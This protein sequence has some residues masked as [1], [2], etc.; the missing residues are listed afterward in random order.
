LAF[1]GNNGWPSWPWGLTMTTHAPVGRSGKRKRDCGTL[2]VKEINIFSRGATRLVSPA[3]SDSSAIFVS[4]SSLV[5]PALGCRGPVWSTWWPSRRP[6]PRLW[7]WGCRWTGRPPGPPWTRPGSPP[8][9]PP[10]DGEKQQSE[11]GEF[12]RQSGNVHVLRHEA[13]AKVKLQK[14]YLCIFLFDGRWKN[15]NN[16]AVASEMKACA[17]GDI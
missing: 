4:S 15:N 8:V 10:G 5:S 3:G 16:P 2:C 17:A 1:W 11:W 6:A 9:S 7:C 12:S 13:A 14:G